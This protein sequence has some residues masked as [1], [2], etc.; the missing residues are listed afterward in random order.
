MTHLLDRKLRCGLEAVI[1][2]KWYRESGYYWLTL[3]LMQH[4]KKCDIITHKC[5]SALHNSKVAEKS[6]P[7][8]MCSIVPSHESGSIALQKSLNKYETGRRNDTNE[9]FLP[10][11]FCCQTQFSDNFVLLLPYLNI[12]VRKLFMALLTAA[13]Q[14]GRRAPSTF[15]SELCTM[16]GTAERVQYLHRD[17]SKY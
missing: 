2:S 10:P 6:I 17:A 12:F 16:M 3:K 1:I 8:S 13:R 15:Y 5:I 11:G 9:T 7:Y 14:H 4:F